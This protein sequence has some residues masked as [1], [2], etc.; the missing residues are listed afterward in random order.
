M[1][2]HMVRNVLI[3]KLNSPVITMFTIPTWFSYCFLLHY[4]EI[5]LLKM[6]NNDPQNGAKLL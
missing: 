2:S 6:S 1:Y 5:F 3:A 4:E